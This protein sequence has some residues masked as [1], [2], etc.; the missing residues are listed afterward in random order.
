M[1]PFE[2]CGQ[3]GDDVNPTWT[4]L[5]PIEGS[6]A[7]A[8][9]GAG[10]HSDLEPERGLFAYG[11]A[12]YSRNGEVLWS[13]DMSD[14]DAPPVTVADVEAL[15][16]ADPD[17]DWRISFDTPMWFGEYQRHGPGVWALVRKGPGFA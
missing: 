17:H 14:E 7:C 13:F 6:L 1:N 2:Q 10:A 9:C 3:A 5:P 15:A 11:S 16:A 8:T 12:D 4:R